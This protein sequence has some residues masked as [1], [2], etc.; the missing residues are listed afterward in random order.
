MSEINNEERIIKYNVCYKYC[1]SCEIYTD[2]LAN[3]YKCLTCIN[4]NYFVNSDNQINNPGRCYTPEE[5]QRLFPNFYLDNDIYKKC[6]ESCSTCSESEDHCEICNNIYFKVDGQ[7]SYTYYELDYINSNFQN[8]YFEK[9]SELY[10]ICNN[11][12]HTCIL[13]S[14][15][16]LTCDIELI[17]FF[18]ILKKI[19]VFNF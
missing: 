10:K 12:C 18:K 2:G 3:D 13:N 4:G 17:F 6:G 9:N 8:Y 15:N 14:N 5:I 19:N 7:D 11:N 1:L 16:C